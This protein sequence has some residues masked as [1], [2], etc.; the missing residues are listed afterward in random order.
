MNNVT[1]SS[2]DWTTCRDQLYQVRHEVFVIGQNVPIEL[3]QDEMDP[4][5][6]HFLALDGRFPVGTARVDREGH[7]GRVAVL[8]SYRGKGVGTK[9]MKAAI[10]RAQ[11]EGCPAALLNSQVSAVEFYSKLGFEPYGAE[12]IEAGIAHVAMR[13]PLE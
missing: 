8:E 3:E 12:F 4:L 13:L 1:V 11:S 7:I 9:L 2:V 5:C 10:Q 6:I